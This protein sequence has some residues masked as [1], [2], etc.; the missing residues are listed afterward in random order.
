MGEYPGGSPFAFNPCYPFIPLHH[1]S[2]H[3]FGSGQISVSRYMAGIY[4]L[5][6]DANSQVRS[7]AMETLVEIYQHVGFKVRLDLSRRGLQASKKN[8][9]T[10]RFDAVDAT[11]GCHQ[12][13]VSLYVF[14]NA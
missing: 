3:S 8:Q 1:N 9:L 13:K 5:I 10:A 12:S 11:T 6:D 2:L 4:T 14:T 7:C